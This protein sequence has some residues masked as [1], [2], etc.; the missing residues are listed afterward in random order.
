MFKDCII[1][2][3][4]SLL[5]TARTFDPDLS[6]IIYEG[7]PDDSPM[8]RL[9]QDIYIFHGASTWLSNQNTPHPDFTRDLSRRQLD[10]PGGVRPADGAKKIAQQCYY[11]E[12]EGGRCYHLGSVPVDFGGGAGTVSALWS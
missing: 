9:L 8:R 12:H 2:A 1:D 7:T 3:F 4:I 6:G 5:L 11:H 10:F